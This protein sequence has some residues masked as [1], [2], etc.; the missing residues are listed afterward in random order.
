MNISLRRTSSPGLFLVLATATLSGCL[1][2]AGGERQIEG[3][4]ADRG[5]FDQNTGAIGG[6]VVDDTLF[7]VADANVT[8]SGTSRAAVTDA[9]G[10]F[11]FMFVEPGEIVLAATKRGFADAEIPVTVEMGRIA[12]AQIVLGPLASDAPYS[13]LLQFN[14]LEVCGLA[15]VGA[16]HLNPCPL[17]ASQT[18]FNFTVRDDWA[19]GIWEMVWETADSMI[20]VATDEAGNCQVA[21]PC[22]GIRTSRSPNRLDAAPAD[23]E[24]AQQYS[25]ANTLYPEDG[26][27]L[28]LDESYAGL[29]RDE[30]NGA[31]G[32]P[33]C[34]QAL[35]S[36]G[37]C[38][39]GVGVSFG[40]RFS[41]YATTF[42][43]ARPLDPQSY[44]A[45]PDG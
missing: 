42:Y 10:A 16:T 40:I 9:A 29:Y 19:Y 18:A 24:I 41:Y 1:G 28:I 7:P 20:F 32:E 37:G 34:H 5:F 33:V 14:G 21:H 13:E 25:L 36:A 17:G 38:P 44:T 3:L 45:I 8:I 6:V 2:D 39:A 15:Y 12:S 43:N 23:L 30:I 31:I 27:D 11:L 4:G 35:G 26:F 22:W